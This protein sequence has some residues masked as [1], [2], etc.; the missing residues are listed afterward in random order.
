V[1]PLDRR[2]FETRGSNYAARVSRRFKEVAVNDKMQRG[3][4][5]TLVAPVRRNFDGDFRPEF[6][7]K[8]MRVLGV[9]SGK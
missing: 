1:I 5:Y 7:P 9:F 6:A 4:R 3:G 2:P 8:E